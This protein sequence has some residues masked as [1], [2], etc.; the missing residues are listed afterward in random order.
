[1]SGKK[2]QPSHILRIHEI[3]HG[4]MQD[5]G[6][7][8][9]FLIEGQ[10]IHRVRLFGIVLDRRENISKS[11]RRFISLRI[12]DGTDTISVTVWSY[13]TREDG[14]VV[15]DPKDMLED[16]Q[17]GDVVDILGRVREYDGEFFISPNSV[18]I[19][20]GIEWE[21]HR[22]TQLVQT[23]LQEKN[24]LGE[25]RPLF[26]QI[27]E[28]TD[29]E[30]GAGLEQLKEEVLQNMDPDQDNTPG[31]LANKLG[32]PQEEIEQVIDELINEAR[33]YQRLPGK[34]QVV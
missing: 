3:H 9:Y 22:R 25:D 33:I 18:T 13:P 7:R 23:A 27:S 5:M 20:D 11:N 8:S 6:D 32:R 12:D 15:F 21:I 14:E 16:V 29:D 26:S 10:P 19:Q 2:R 34:Y 31:I 28:Q 24:L 4:E 1:M 30:A 17:P